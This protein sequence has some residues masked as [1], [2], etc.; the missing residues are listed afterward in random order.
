M[1]SSGSVRAEAS[2]RIT[3]SSSPLAVGMVATRSSSFWP[4]IQRPKLIL[5]SCGLRRSEMSRSHM[6]FSRATIAAR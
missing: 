1:P 4:C 6:I 3:T 5:P 2:S